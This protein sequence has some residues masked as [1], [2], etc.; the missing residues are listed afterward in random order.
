MIKLTKPLYCDVDSFHVQVDLLGF[1][2]YSILWDDELTFRFD[3]ELT[4]EQQMQLAAVVAAHD[5]TLA[6]A[7]REER[8]AKIA[9]IVSTNMALVESAREKRLLGEPLTPLEL[10]A[11]VDLLIFP[12]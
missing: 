5:G 9:V 10:A 3:T 4:A 1:G 6:I 2:P 12:M 11:L 8:E 7:A